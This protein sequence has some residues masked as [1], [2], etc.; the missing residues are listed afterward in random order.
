MANP[1]ITK[2]NAWTIIKMMLQYSGYLIII[3]EG[4]S[5]IINAIERKEK[6]PTNES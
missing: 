4:L 6:T 3:I 2:T 1:Q 5:S